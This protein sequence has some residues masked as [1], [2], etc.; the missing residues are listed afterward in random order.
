MSLEGKIALVTGAGRGIGKAAAVALAQAGAD[1]AIADIDTAS[2]EET[3]GA[4]EAMGRRSL[5]V[6]ADLGD[7]EHI[8]ALVEKTVGALGGIDILVNNAALTQHGQVLGGHRGDLGQA[9]SRQRQGRV[10]LRQRVARQMAAQA[11]AG[12]SSTSPRSP[13]RVTPRPPTRP[14]PRARAR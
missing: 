12:G 14:M 8:D 1:V 7:L 5:A 11:A 13:A 9:A 3:R 2:A 4:I 6:P 10:L